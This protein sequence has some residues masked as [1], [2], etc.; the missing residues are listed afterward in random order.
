MGDVN[1]DGLSVAAWLHSPGELTGGGWR[2]ALYIDERANEAQTAALT[3][4][5]GGEVGGHPAVLAGLVGELMG[6]KSV[7]TSYSIHY[8]KLYEM[9]FLKAA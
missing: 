3:K 6:V 2:L 7:I 4:I 8:T 9:D 5:Y 1:L